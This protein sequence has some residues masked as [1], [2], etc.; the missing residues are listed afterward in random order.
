ML[1]CLDHHN[2]TQQEFNLSQLYG[3]E[4]EAQVWTGLAPLGPLSWAY[5]LCVP[6]CS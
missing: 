5:R 6:L 4:G 2:K 1:A 3:L